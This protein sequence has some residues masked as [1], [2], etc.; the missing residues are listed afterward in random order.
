MTT[1]PAHGDQD[2]VS[3]LAASP[4]GSPTHDRPEPGQHFPPPTPA[5]QQPLPTWVANP[6][7]NPNLIWTGIALA[8]AALVMSLLGVLAG[9]GWFVVL[10]LPFWL[11]H[12]ANVYLGGAFY[13]L[14]HHALDRIR[15]VRAAT[16][17]GAPPLPPVSPAPSPMMRRN[18]IINGAAL[19]A[20]LIGTILWWDTAGAGNP[21]NTKCS[22]FMAMQPKQQQRLLLSLPYSDMNMLANH[23]QYLTSC[24]ASGGKLADLMP[25][26]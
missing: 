15:T 4:P 24:A 6:A 8:Q 23:F 22:D 16:E 14:P 7:Q 9:W 18:L 11:I 13:E 20:L 3:G 25:R 26:N 12:T 19:V 10:T 2:P 1:F 21:I 5:G 17:P